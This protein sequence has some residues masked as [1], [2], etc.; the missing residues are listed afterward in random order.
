MGLYLLVMAHFMIIA[1]FSRRIAADDKGN[2]A[3]CAM[4][5][6]RNLAGF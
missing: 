3:G 1:A 4:I 5:R 2:H 6:G